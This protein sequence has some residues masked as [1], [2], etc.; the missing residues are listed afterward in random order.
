MEISGAE[1]GA[2][3]E[4]VNF[5]RRGV[6]E[7]EAPGVPG[8]DNDGVGGCGRRDNAGIAGAGGSPDGVCQPPSPAW[9]TLIP[10]DSVSLFTDNR[11]DAQFQP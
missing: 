11:H 10:A 5:G 8:S 6:A 7:P 9:S 4:I 1:A 2:T 3:E